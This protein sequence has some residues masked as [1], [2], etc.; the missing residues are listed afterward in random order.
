MGPSLTV[1]GVRELADALVTPELVVVPV[2]HHSPACAWHV[3]QVMAEH[4]PSVV[5]VE[6]PRSFT[7]LVPLLTH[8][9]ARM[10]LAV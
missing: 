3:R 10:P 6:G 7:P 2:R 4:R 1:E 9:Q 5:L 8:P